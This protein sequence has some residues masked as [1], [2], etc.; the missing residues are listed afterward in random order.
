MTDDKIY[1]WELRRPDLVLRAVA[2]RQPFDRPRTLLA[3]IDGPYD[4]QR[5]VGVTELWVDPAEDELE[6]TTLTEQALQ[7]LGFGYTDA[8]YPD[9]PMAVAIVVRPG[10][11]WWSWDEQEAFLGLRYGSHLCD[12]IQGDLLT[13]TSHGW[14]SWPGDLHGTKP[15]AQWAA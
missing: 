3:R 1:P 14:M 15:R 7:R 6:R 11:C 9:Y 10:S 12:V 2:E 8:R 13:V 5:L 4:G